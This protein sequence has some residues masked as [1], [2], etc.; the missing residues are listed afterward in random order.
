VT[1]ARTHT[2]THRLSLSLSLSLSP[3]SGVWGLPL[4][5]FGRAPWVHSALSVS[6]WG[7]PPLA[8]LSC[9]KASVVRLATYHLT[10][11]RWHLN[12]CWPNGV[13]A[14][15]TP[16]HCTNL[17]NLRPPASLLHCWDQRTGQLAAISAADELQLIVS[18]CSWNT[19]LLL[20]AH[21]NPNSEYFSHIPKLEWG[22]QQQSGFIAP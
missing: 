4:A 11:K 12:P 10:G 22:I 14:T 17:T 16:G 21:K 20:E 1:H 2:H 13:A 9:R 18:K 15:D 19:S 7:R 8:A 6:S 3:P 5:V